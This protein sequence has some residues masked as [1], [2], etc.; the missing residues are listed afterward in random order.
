MREREAQH[1]QRAAPHRP[2]A[3]VEP[4]LARTHVGARDV[5][6]VHVAQ[7]VDRVELSARPVTTVAVDGPLGERRLDLRALPDVVREHVEHREVFAAFVSA[8]GSTPALIFSAASATRASLSVM[9]PC[10]PSRTR[11]V[12]TNLPLRLRPVSYARVAAP[13]RPGLRASR[14]SGGS[15]LHTTRFRHW[16]PCDPRPGYT[17]SVTRACKSLRVDPLPFR[18]SFSLRS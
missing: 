14:Q 5:A 2:A 15:G 6:R 13:S 16:P 1:A 10:L 9:S 11:T 12:R 4:R 8:F 17:V 18:D 7:A 3:L